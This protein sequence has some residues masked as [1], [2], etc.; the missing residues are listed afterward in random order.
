MP[1]SACPAAA[2]HPP[3][4]TL[5]YN[6]PQ[7]F[8]ISPLFGNAHPRPF[9]APPLLSPPDQISVSPTGEW[10]V[11][12]H[13]NPQHG[14]TL[15]IY[16][17]STLSPTATL[18]SVAPL[19]TFQLSSE[20]LAITHLYTPRTHLSH[21]RS[22]PRG[23]S[24]PPGHDPSRGPT[25]TILTAHQVL[26]IHPQAI[27]PAGGLNVPPS[28]AMSCI[29]SS[30]WTRSFSKD[31]VPG[32]QESGKPIERGW[33]D[34]VAGNRGVWIGYEAEG[35]VGVV[36][37]DVDVDGNGDY[38]L[39]TTRLPSLPF[40]DCPPLEG[41]ETSDCVS[42]LKDMVFVHIPREAQVSDQGAESRDI[43]MNDEK[44]ESS[45]NTE[46]AG[47]VLVY[48]DYVPSAPD[49]MSRSR[50]VTVAFERR[51][52]QLAPGFSE[53]SDASTEVGDLWDW[54]T[55]PEPS[56]SVCS[57]T[58]T[59]ILSLHLLP[60]L[61]PYSITL[62]IISTPTGLSRVHLDLA[63][64]QWS[65]LSD[66][67]LGGL[68]RDDLVLLP[69]QGVER[70]H[71]G[72]C[73][74]VGRESLQLGAVRTLNEQPPIGDHKPEHLSREESQ[75]IS[76]ATSIILAER[77]GSDWSDVVRALTAIVSSS[78]QSSFIN[79][80]LRRIYSL[81]EEESAIDQ[82]DLLC[83]VQVALFS[84][85]KDSRLR[86]AADIL[87]LYAASELLDNCATFEEDGSITFDLD[88]IWPLISVLDW[89]LFLISNSMR[90]SLILRATSSNHSA[91]PQDLLH[92]P[93]TPILI[94]FH[95]TL[96][97]LVLRVLSQLNQL[98]L[99]LATLGRPILQPEHGG[100]GSARRRDPMATIV[101]R[102]MAGDL[103]GKWGVDLEGWGKTLEKMDEFGEDHLPS[104]ETSLTSLFVTPIQEHL[105]AFLEALYDSSLLFTSAAAVH[106]RDA[107]MEFDALEWTLLSPLWNGEDKG[108]RKR[109]VQC[110]RCAS[111]TEAL[112]R[113]SRVQGP[114]TSPW[115]RWKE[116][117]TVHCFCG[118]TWI[119]SE[120]VA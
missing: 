96:R 18:Q 75:A 40:I 98:V 74:I 71:L 1:S 32:P 38:H 92:H 52:L 70:G 84:A 9:P 95:P 36:R 10:I 89:C 103:A 5:I 97:R 2:L 106:F 65:T 105:P 79:D 17:Q 15:A 57:P 118:G 78:S 85:F 13:P 41:A 63:S 116:A 120:V 88:S 8:L 6:S 46:R 20:P 19:A 109:I 76:A 94:L 3:T 35:K 61:P 90:Q 87:R 58:G 67:R 108:T 80:L 77:Q 110:N 33:M 34:S 101:A 37:A 24:P 11:A 43:E 66:Y 12:Y 83:R 117:S 115:G 111:R 104:V 22:L 81:S 62:T 73:A 45:A 7:G 119:R 16:P 60:S 50:L 25:F 91:P 112:A 72:L 114:P 30:I 29:Q 21:A 64:A 26:L 99:F 54:F 31:G 86:L 4:S 14:G 28:W 59:T 55:A 113:S 23:P 51:L 107:P 68:Q 56:Q 69:S 27:P 44:V 47:V 39:Q 49:S 102:E 100:M 48:R 93:H 53:M 42:T 82:M